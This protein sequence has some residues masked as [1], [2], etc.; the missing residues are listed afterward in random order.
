MEQPIY[1]VDAFAE[2]P[3]SGNPAAIC[4]LDAPMPESL[5]QTIAM[6]M[7]QAET[8]FVAKRA[9][10]S[11]DLRWFTPTVEVDLCG[12]ATLASA[13]VLW[14]TGMLTADATAHFHTRS[15]LLTAT[16]NQDGIT[17]DFPAEVV[18]AIVMPQI[19]AAIDVPVKFVGKNRI[20]YFAEIESET[21]VRNFTP[22]LRRIADLGMRGLIITAQADTTAE[23][24][25]VSRFFAPAAGIDED[26]AT[27]SAHCGLAPYWRDK[28]GREALVGYQ[29][30]PRGAIIRTLCRDSR[31][32]LTGNV[33][34]T[35][36]GTLHL[37]SIS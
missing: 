25:F 33:V 6:E 19:A 9:D 37:P 22:D 30:S 21:A 23:Y 5:M 16:K 18:S 11:F 24:D 8:A 1:L 3:F 34:L 20:A 31:V 35:L 27:G 4:I 36:T 7:N 28:L 17:L 13:F 29:A 10:G 15:G 2:R 26:P 32:L 12:H 14:H